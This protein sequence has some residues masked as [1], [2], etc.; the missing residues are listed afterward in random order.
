MPKEKC[1]FCGRV[2]EEDT[3]GHCTVCG[4]AMCDRCPIA[5][6]DY[7]VSESLEVCG[8]QESRSG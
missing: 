3:F 8:V 6:C 5:C 1:S 2:G 4:A 7:Q